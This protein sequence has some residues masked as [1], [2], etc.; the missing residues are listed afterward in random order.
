MRREREEEKNRQ[1]CCRKERDLSRRSGEI[2][3][4]REDN[5]FVGGRHGKNWGGPTFPIPGGGEISKQG[6]QGGVLGEKG[7]KKV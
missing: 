1:L 6:Y 2:P 7:E 3:R 4:D 5:P